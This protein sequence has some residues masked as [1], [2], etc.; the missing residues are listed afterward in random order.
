MLAVKKFNKFQ[1]MLSLLFSFKLQSCFDNNGPTNRHLSRLTFCFC[2]TTNLGKP[3]FERYI[4]GA[5][6]TI[7]CLFGDFVPTGLSPPRWK[8]PPKKQK[9]V[10]WDPLIEICEQKS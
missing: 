10:F 8:I 6:K 4:K 1:K 9:F 2:T 5:Q 3:F 7:F